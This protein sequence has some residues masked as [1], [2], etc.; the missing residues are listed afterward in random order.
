MILRPAKKEEFPELTRGSERDT[1]KTHAD[2]KSLY[3][4][5]DGALF[6]EGARY[7]IEFI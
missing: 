3:Y 1:G 2:E 5:T 6:A 4:L 7:D